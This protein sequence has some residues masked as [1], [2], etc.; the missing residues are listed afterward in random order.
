MSK[1]KKDLISII[2]PCYNEEE[3]LPIFYKEI[4]K[5]NKL[6][7]EL[8]L[9]SSKDLKS[10]E[11]TQNLRTQY[12]E[13]ISPLKAQKEIYMKLYN[14]TDNAADKTILKAR[15]NILNEDIERLNKKIQTCK[16]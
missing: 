11:D 8:S 16:E 9:I 6:C 7:D 10:I 1:E 3:S 2:V 15:I 4:N 13:E 5:F 14:K 12:L